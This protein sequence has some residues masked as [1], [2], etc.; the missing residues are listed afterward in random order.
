MLELMGQSLTDLKRAL[1]G[2]I[3]MSAALDDL[4]TCIFKG[5]V[6]PQWLRFAPQSMKSL[7]NWFEHFL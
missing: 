7:V 2:E 6:P 4:A 1:V 5:F 3:G